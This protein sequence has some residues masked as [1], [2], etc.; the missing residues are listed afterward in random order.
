M[1]KRLIYL[2]ILFIIICIGLLSRGMTGFVTEIID[3]KDVVW[4]MMIY[5]LF[6]VVFI[7]W[8]IKKVAL[9]GMLFSILVE[10][11]QLYHN[12]WID[13]LRGTFFGELMLGT[14]F[15]W[16]DLMAYLFGIGFGIIIDYF[17]VSYF[18]NSLSSSG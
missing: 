2:L 9:A 3:F 13:T 11:S 14:N 8:S 18:K 17:V 10:L 16:S 15:V 6:R 4:A 1:T 5:F 12:D 7:G